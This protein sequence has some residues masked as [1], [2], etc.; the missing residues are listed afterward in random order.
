MDQER[1]R[2]ALLIERLDKIGVETTNLVVEWAKCHSAAKGQWFISS[3]EEAVEII[4]RGE[5]L[6]VDPFNEPRRDLA[7]MLTG[8][9]RKYWSFN[10][11]KEHTHSWHDREDFIDKLLPKLLEVNDR[12]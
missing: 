2:I 8:Q 6:P 7:A 4:N 11:R 5:K 9:L 3:L 12:I 10:N 1:S